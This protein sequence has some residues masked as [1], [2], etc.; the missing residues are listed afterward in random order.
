MKHD[1]QNVVGGVAAASSHLPSAARLLDAVFV[2]KN[3]RQSVRAGHIESSV[4]SM[5]ARVA[6]MCA[7]VASMC[8]KDA[9]MC[10][11]VASMCAKVT[12]KAG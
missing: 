6:S 11:E 4:A 8:A 5:C 12:F 10:A 3:E 7:K 1:G 9:S 2:P